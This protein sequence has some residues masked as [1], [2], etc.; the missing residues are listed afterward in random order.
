MSLPVKLT[1]RICE[2]TVTYTTE[3]KYPLT[4]SSITLF[5]SPSTQLNAVLCSPASLCVCLLPEQVVH[6]GFMRALPPET[7]SFCGVKQCYERS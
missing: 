3:P 4:L 6:I 2:Q 1:W 7:V 5:W